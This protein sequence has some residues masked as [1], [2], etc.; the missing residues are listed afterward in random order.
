M[1]TQIVRM[2]RACRKH[3]SS[4]AV[5]DD[6]RMALLVAS[7]RLPVACCPLPLRLRFSIFGFPLRSI[8]VAD[9]NGA[10][11]Q[12]QVKVKSSEV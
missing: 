11:V 3:T 5:R 12:E 10:H 1:T 6:S 2:L 4:N 9:M 7:C 8:Y